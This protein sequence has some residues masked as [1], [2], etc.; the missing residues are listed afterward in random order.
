MLLDAGADTAVRDDLLDSTPL[1]WAS[2]WGRVEFVELLLER[3]AD[4]NEAVDSGLF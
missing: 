3:G 1:G 2:R 4:P